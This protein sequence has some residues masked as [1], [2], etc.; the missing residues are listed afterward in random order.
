MLQLT[1]LVEGKRETR[2]LADGVYLIG[3]GEGCR[4][5]FPYPDVSERHAILTVRGGTAMIEDLHSANG[6]YAKGEMIDAP[7]TLSG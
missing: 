7:V 6:T 3:R 1:T 5:R 4:I 2:E